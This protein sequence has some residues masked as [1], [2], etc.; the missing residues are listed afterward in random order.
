MAKIHGLREGTMYEK[1]ISKL[2]RSFG[3][4]RDGNVTHYVR[5]GYGRKTNNRGN[6]GKHYNPSIRDRR[7]NALMDQWE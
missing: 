2:D 4:M 6:Y 5:V 3:Y 7:N 1:H